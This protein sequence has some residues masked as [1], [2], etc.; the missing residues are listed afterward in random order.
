L[1]GGIM[2]LVAAISERR[3]QRRLAAA[4]APDLTTPTA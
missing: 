1:I 2:S 3:S 4:G